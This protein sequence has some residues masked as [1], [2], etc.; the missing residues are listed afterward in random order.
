MKRRQPR[1][2]ELDP[3]ELLGAP[4][5]EAYG[6]SFQDHLLAQYTMY[7]EMAD[8]ITAR[9]QTTNTFFLTVNTLLVAF[10]GVLASDPIA[11]PLP[12]AVSV[13]IAGVTLSYSWYRIIQSYRDLNRAKFEVI[14]ALERML[15]VR[16]FGAEWD[17]VGRGRRSHLY[18]PLT[19]VELRVPWVFAS[20]YV[21]LAVSHVAGAT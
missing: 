13:A 7:V 9:R 10:L 4:S 20:L 15:P 14:H 6:G 2:S 8:R 19:H 11:P 21:A 17:A 18:L 1:A 12:W 3:E 5:A 16:L